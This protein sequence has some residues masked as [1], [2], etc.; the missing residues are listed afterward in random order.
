MLATHRDFNI[1]ERESGRNEIADDLLPLRILKAGDLK[2]QS[3]ALN[4]FLTQ[5]FHEPR[6]S[7]GYLL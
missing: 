6:G 4:Y 2:F 1:N 5:F 3:T 7:D